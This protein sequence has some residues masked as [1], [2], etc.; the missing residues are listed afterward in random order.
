MNR[1]SNFLT[2][3]FVRMRGIFSGR[4]ASRFSF[5]QTILFLLVA[6]EV[7]ARAGG[8][9]S[10][11]SSSSS[12]SSSHSSGGG[13]GGGGDD[14]IFDIVFDILWWLIGEYPAIGIPL[15]VIIVFAIYY[16]GQEGK[17]QYVDYTIR[18]GFQ[19]QSTVAQANAQTALQKRD[20]N[21]RGS[22]F[23]ARMKRAFAAIQDGWTKQDLKLFQAFVSDGVYERFALQIAEMKESGIIDYMDK[24]DI[25]DA[26][27]A[28][29][30]SDMHYDTI[31]VYFKA[32]VVNYRIDAKTKQRL[33]G[34]SSPE[35]FDEY[36]SFLRKPGAK[37][38]VKGG[39]IEGYC[40]N[41]SAPI[42]VARVATCT[43]CNS[44]L[45]SG[46]YD[47]VLSEITQSCEWVP[48]EIVDIAGLREFRKSDPGFNPQAIE[49]RASVVF[50]RY[51]TAERLGDV[52]PMK[53]FAVDTFVAG[54]AEQLRPIADGSRSFW[55]DCAV[56]SVD[57]IGIDTG[58][59]DQSIQT[60]DAGFDRLFVKIR[61]SGKQLTRSR[62]GR[63]D[64]KSSTARNI[65]KAFVFKRRCGV[66]TE[67]RNSLASGHCVNCGAPE[68]TG[69]E[70]ICEYCGTVQND[71]TRDW[72]LDSIKSATE[73][74]IV[75]AIQRARTA[76]R[77]DDRA[78]AER[79][80]AGISGIGGEFGMTFGLS[81]APVAEMAPPK[82]SAEA[83]RYMIAM[84]LA[85]GVVDPKE[86]TMLQAFG[87][88]CGVSDNQLNEMIWS[89]QQSDNNFEQSGF[90][91]NA[92]AAHEI[93]R[94]MAAMAL[95]DGRLSD[96]E[97]GALQAFGKRI[98]LSSSDVKMLVNK[99]R[100]RLY[101]EAKKAISVSKKIII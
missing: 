62:D 14:I 10:Y 93:L 65:T 88:Q 73:P 74:E 58:S 92:E 99:E 81:G 56:G 71:G 31:H 76:Q 4:K 51:V 7:W 94:A 37:T 40:P 79:V 32:S 27:I 83:L 42:S 48:A 61:W 87:A 28:H 8:G 90:P 60:K 20:P 35:T 43:A 91:E 30:Q 46:E 55:G 41:C 101:N 26:R 50:W 96:D 63:I 39:L 85:D 16:G 86:K 9:H 52:G 25:L 49:D 47:W 45:R 64:G 24:L 98:S 18:R 38:L 66:Q 19:A 17:E 54:M 89:A 95:A 67:T 59:D 70:Y 2:L 29:I 6:G 22:D 78:P 36:W 15:C 11:S 100:S 68:K 1:I 5:L 12:S 82:S 23:I 97:L 57:L 69:Q 13:H 75:T 3:L 44:Y 84:M 21:F 33:E 53:R 34:S 72:V 77:P 80:P